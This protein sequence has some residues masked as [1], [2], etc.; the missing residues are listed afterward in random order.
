MFSTND[1]SRVT[2]LC[3]AA[4]LIAGAVPGFAASGPNPPGQTPSGKGEPCVAYAA[5]V[6]GTGG[7]D[8]IR[9]CVTEDGNVQTYGIGSTRWIQDGY[10]LCYRDG[11]SSIVSGADMGPGSGIGFGPSTIQ[12]P[13]GP[14]TFPLTVTRWTTAPD[15]AFTQVFELGV[16]DDVDLHV[17]MSADYFGDGSIHDVR[18]VRE[19]DRERPAV[20]KPLS[21]SGW[22][23]ILKTKEK[24]LAAT[25][26][27]SSLGWT[28]GKRYG[29][30]LT[31]PHAGGTV[32]SLPGSPLWETGIVDGTAVETVEAACGGLSYFKYQ[33][34]GDLHG[35]AVFSL[36]TLQSVGTL[37][38]SLVNKDVRFQYRL[39]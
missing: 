32:V 17:T 14:G 35:R 23:P 28:E 8:S 3:A 38:P 36:G 39:F 20:K 21:Y 26:E 29:L 10:R 31:S 5:T 15:V 37:Q 12:Q 30:M 27:D 24:G 6:K 1:V 4:T 13:N 33:G 16:G 22:T 2:A 9:I 18:I 25:T 19:F 7:F 34:P 11:G